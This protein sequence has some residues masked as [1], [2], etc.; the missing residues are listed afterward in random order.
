MSENEVYCT[1]PE[2]GYG[3]HTVACVPLADQNDKQL[4]LLRAIWGLCPDC[5]RTDEHEHRE[6]T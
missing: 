5:N 6:I 4:R 2:H 3:E 1:M